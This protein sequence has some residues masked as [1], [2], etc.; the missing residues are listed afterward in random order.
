V[1]ED[2]E[3]A[4]KTVRGVL[5]YQLPDGFVANYARWDVPQ[6]N[7]RN[8]CSMDRSQPPVGSMSAWK[9]H[10]HPPDLDFLAEVYPKLVRWHEWRPKA[11]DGKVTATPE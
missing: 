6:D 11:R 9:M 2:P 4:R 5:A 7:E 1:L 3:G 10:E 8:F